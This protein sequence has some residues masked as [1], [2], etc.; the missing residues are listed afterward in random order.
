MSIS[1]HAGA[2]REA[3][4]EGLASVQVKHLLSMY[5]VPHIS[6]VHV[7]F[8][9]DLLLP[10]HPAAQAAAASRAPVVVVDGEQEPGRTC[11]QALGFGPGHETTAAGLFPIE[12]IPWDSL[13]FPS[14]RCESRQRRP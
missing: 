6:Q 5:S 10:E 8:L 14:G 9:A 12:D 4:E 1:A 3:E 11:E 13:A 2:A 7:W